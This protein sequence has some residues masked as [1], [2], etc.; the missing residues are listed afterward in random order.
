MSNCLRSRVLPRFANNRRRI[1]RTDSL[2]E[3]QSYTNRTHI[4][5]IHLRPTAPTTLSLKTLTL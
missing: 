4:Q 1:L 2:E 5:H 3:S